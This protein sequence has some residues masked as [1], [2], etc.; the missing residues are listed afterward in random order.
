MALASILFVTPHPHS[1]YDAC[2]RWLEGTAGRAGGVESDSECDELLVP[3]LREWCRQHDDAGI[4]LGRSVHDGNCG[5][6][7]VVPRCSVSLS[8]RALSAEARRGDEGGQ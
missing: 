4:I 8:L 7:V 6:G 2:A 1:K 5:C 3:R